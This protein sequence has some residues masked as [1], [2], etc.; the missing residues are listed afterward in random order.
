MKKFVFIN[1]FIIFL[2][3]FLLFYFYRSVYAQESFAPSVSTDIANPIY[4]DGY[5]QNAFLGQNHSY[6]VVFRGNGEAVVSARVVVANSDDKDL[7]ELSL[8]IPKANVSDIYVFQIFKQKRCVRYTQTVYDPVTRSYPP[9]VCAEY[10]DPDYY[11]DYSYYSAKYKKAE[12]ELNNDTLVI[13][14]PEGI[15]ADKAGAFFIYFRALGYA[16]KNAYKAFDYTFETLQAE[17][18]IRSLNIGISTDSDLFMKG[19]TGEVNYRFQ[20]LSPT[21]A[22]LGVG[23]AS[24]MGVSNSALDSYV[25]NIGQGSI[26]KSASNLAPLE[27]YTVK[28]SYADSR[29]KLYGKEITIAAIVLLSLLVLFIIIS[30]VVY[31]LLK[32]R[33][34]PLKKAPEGSTTVKEKG[35]KIQNTS[36]GRMFLVVTLIGFVDSLIIA[37]YTVSIVFFASFISRSVTYTYQGLVVLILV[38]IS[39]L[40]YL[41]LIVSPGVILGVKKSVAWG[42]GAVISTILWLILWAMLIFVGI[43]LL[44]NSIKIDNIIQPLSRVVY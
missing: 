7:E 13:K 16:K 23:G 12:Y 29:I 36:S 4:P 8:R 1:L 31:R 3:S 17:D 9:A 26:Y 28:G 22:K 38:I 42:M 44:G 18:S 14:I 33:D 39:I 21:I 25:T 10:Q 37:V 34:N 15:A 35:F 41:L 27:S 2:S 40:I 5:Q 43:F 20:D 24:E 11:N 19:V 32:R 6:S 30:I